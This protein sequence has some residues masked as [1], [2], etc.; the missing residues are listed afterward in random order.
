LRICADPPERHPRIA[1][2][3]WG[4]YDHEGD[5]H[6]LNLSAGDLSASMSDEFGLLRWSIRW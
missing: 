3:K 4:L 5:L 6:P 2:P 1:S